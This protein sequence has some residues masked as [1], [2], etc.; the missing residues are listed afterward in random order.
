MVL[1]VKTDIKNKLFKIKRL[2]AMSGN[3]MLCIRRKV[4]V[5][6]IPIFNVV[7]KQRSSCRMG[8]G[9]AFGNGKQR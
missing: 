4:E 9:V 7:L 1:A 2:S 6:Y 3:I 5:I 8:R